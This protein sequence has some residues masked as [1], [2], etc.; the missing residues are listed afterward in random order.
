M[1]KNRPSYDFFR[2]VSA[3]SMIAALVWLTVSTPYIFR[4]QQDVKKAE[5]AKNNTP[6]S[7]D[8]EDNNP[9]ANTTE[10][11]TSSVNTMTEEY[12]HHH[13]D[14]KLFSH[15]IVNLFGNSSEALYI[16]FHGELISPPPDIF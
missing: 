7:T 4:Y 14:H 1:K 6:P 16:A 11:K 8:N 10:E 9:F 15:T 2:K 12:L 3:I 13:E 5:I